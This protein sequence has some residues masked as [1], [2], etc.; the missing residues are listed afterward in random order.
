M[1]TE[2]GRRAGDTGYDKDGRRLSAEVHTLSRAW[3]EGCGW[4][5][6]DRSG[7]ELSDADAARHDTENAAVHASM[8]PLPA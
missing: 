1:N 4:F 6:P 2:L 3:C 5:G 7:R 8:A